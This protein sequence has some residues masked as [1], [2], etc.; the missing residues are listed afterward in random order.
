MKLNL[1]AM[2]MGIDSSR[3][4]WVFRV[5]RGFFGFLNIRSENITI[6]MHTKFESG[7]PKRLN[8]IPLDI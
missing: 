1:T 5:P 8:Y 2:E 4:S 6:D 3:L 7:V